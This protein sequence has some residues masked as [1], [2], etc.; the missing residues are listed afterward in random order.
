MEHDQI[1]AADC[2]CIPFFFPVV[3]KCDFAPLQE[4]G[5][6]SAAQTRKV[7]TISV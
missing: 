6:L 5:G 7:A 3:S 4:P 1:H 2:I